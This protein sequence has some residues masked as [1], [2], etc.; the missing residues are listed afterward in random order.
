MQKLMFLMLLIAILCLLIITFPSKE[1]YAKAEPVIEVP[2]VEEIEEVK[3]VVTIK[4]MIEE[5]A[6]MFGQDPKLISK[7]AW[8]ESKHKSVVHDNGHG[9]GVTGF[10]KATFARY[11]KRYQKE[12][13]EWLDYDS[14][15]DQLKLMSYAFSK[16]ESARR[17]WST[18]RAYTNGGTYSFYSKL[19]DAHFTVRCS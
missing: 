14:S 6:P 2:V 17:E 18:Y 5:V 12:G 15:Y 8:C 16:G 1:S 11:L 4:E 3:K 13:G 7:I 9:K 10:H 19:L